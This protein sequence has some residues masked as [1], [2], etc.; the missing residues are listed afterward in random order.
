MTNNI[1]TGYLLNAILG[2]LSLLLVA[3]LFSLGTRMYHPRIDN[4]RSEINTRLISSIIQLE[5]LNGCGVS[6]LATIYTTKLRQNGFDVVETGNFDTFDIPETLVIDRA[7]NYQNVKKIAD[8][9]GV[10]ERNIIRESSPD[11]YLDATV[12]IGSDYDNLKLN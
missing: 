3:L 9:L 10:S 7:G 2:F 5:V 11:Y 6:G 1:K 12:V 8:A 4:E